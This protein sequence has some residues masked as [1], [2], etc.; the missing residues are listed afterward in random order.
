MA[1]TIQKRLESKLIPIT[2]SGCLL[3]EGSTDKFGYGKILVS[4]HTNERAHRIAW[5][6]QNGEIPKGFCVLHKCDIPSCCNINH[7]FLGTK[8]DN[9]QDK[10]V[11][12]RGLK[13]LTIESIKNIKNSNL[14]AK[15]LGQT[16]GVTANLVYQIK[17]GVCG[18]YA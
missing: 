18:V 17:R 3:F 12:G 1:A 14:S 5:I 7:L 6:L 16:Y 15:V 2:E 13:K 8:K 11:K 9:N 10:A 4:G